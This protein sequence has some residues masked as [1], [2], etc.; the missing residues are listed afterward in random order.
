VMSEDRVVTLC[1]DI[2]FNYF[3]DADGLRVVRVQDVRGVEH[4][5]PSEPSE[6]EKY[7]YALEEFKQNY[8]GNTSRPGT[9]VFAVLAGDLEDIEAKRLQAA[10]KELLERNDTGFS[11]GSEAK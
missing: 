3:E 10:A 8:G 4:E 5:V 1:D 11:D 7:D 2:S 6:A 9:P